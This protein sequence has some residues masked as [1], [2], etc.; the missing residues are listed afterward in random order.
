[1]LVSIFIQPHFHQDQ[2]LR[3]W[4]RIRILDR[5]SISVE[6]QDDRKINI[7]APKPIICP[8]FSPTKFENSCDEDVVAEDTVAEDTV[9]ED[10]V[11]E[12]AVTEDAVAN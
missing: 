8:V 7:K 6:D 2:N 5:S 3:S 11:A 4:S 1:M 10:A 9:V 12:A